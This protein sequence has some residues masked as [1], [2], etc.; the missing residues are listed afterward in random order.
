M[1]KF[2][3]TLPLEQAEILLEMLDDYYRVTPAEDEAIEALRLQVTLRRS[4]VA[5]W[6]DAMWTAEFGPAAC[7]Y[8]TKEPHGPRHKPSSHCESGKRTHC[9]CPICWG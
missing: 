7:D 2:T 3:T 1:T 5:I 4:D 9:T 6:Q 8:C